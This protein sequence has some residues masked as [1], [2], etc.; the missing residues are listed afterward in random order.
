MAISQ[1]SNP[2]APTGM[3]LVGWLYHTSGGTVPK[4]SGNISTAYSVPSNQKLTLTFSP[5]FSNANYLIQVTPEYGVSMP[6]IQNKTAASVDIIGASLSNI[7]VE[8][9]Q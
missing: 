3:A 1:T 2:R 9:Y 6:Q 7:V 5:A 8:I 4:K